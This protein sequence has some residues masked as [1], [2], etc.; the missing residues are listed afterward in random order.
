MELLDCPGGKEGNELVKSA[1]LLATGRLLAR[2]ASGDRSAVD[3]LLARHRDRLRRMVAIR[4]DGRLAA[5]VDPSDVVQDTLADAAA[6]MGEYLREPSA[7]FH[8]WLRRIAWSRLVDAYRRHIL[9][10][11]RSVLREQPLGLSD[12]S[13][14]Q[15]AD[16]LLSSGADPVRRMICDELR[17][18]VKA[19]LIQLSEQDQEILVLHHLEQLPMTECAAIMNTSVAAAKKRYVRAMER[20]RGLLEPIED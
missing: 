18:R 17:A 5:R 19:T 12:D 10:E 16:Q 1:E 15:L 4:M 8:L 7:P 20:L 6:R 9:R 2:A 3:D 14:L 11:S 13:A